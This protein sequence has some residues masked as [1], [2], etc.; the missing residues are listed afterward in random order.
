MRRKIFFIL[1]AIFVTFAF[2]M[3]LLGV[4]SIKLH[5]D[6]TLAYPVFSVYYDTF[7]S[8][9]TAETLEYFFPVVDTTI[10]TNMYGEID[11]LVEEVYPWPSVYDQNSYEAW[12]DTVDGGVT[13]LSL[14]R[15]AM[16]DWALSFF[17]ADSSNAGVTHDVTT[18][19]QYQFPG[20]PAWT[21]RYGLFTNADAMDSLRTVYPFD[22]Y[23]NWKLYRNAKLTVIIADYDSLLIQG[24]LVGRQIF[25]HRHVDPGE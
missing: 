1:V 13:Y 9:A 2:S 18:F 24:W 8:G 5:R 19:L 10:D 4:K 15:W 11:T 20:A 21:V 17:I 16:E 25:Q 3:S 23:D 6:Y 12:L 7:P 14:E 22:L